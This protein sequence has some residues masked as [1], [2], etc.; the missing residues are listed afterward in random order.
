MNTEINIDFLNA[1]FTFFLDT[2]EAKN[3][4]NLKDKDIDALSNEINLFGVD[5]LTE[6]EYYR[7]AVEYL[8]K[9]KICAM[10]SRDFLV[11]KIKNI[12]APTLSH[13]AEIEDIFKQFF[14]YFKTQKIDVNSFP[15]NEFLIEKLA[16]MCNQDLSQFKYKTLDP[17]PENVV[18]YEKVYEDFIAQR[19]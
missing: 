3:C 19:I 12:V 17:I 4:D 6:L 8:N 14:T 18:K 5:K 2:I 15:T 10:Y 13:R 1:R 7:I 11:N 9:N 16:S